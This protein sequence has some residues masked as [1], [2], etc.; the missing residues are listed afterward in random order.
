MAQVG[1]RTDKIDHWRT[2]DQRQRCVATSLLDLEPRLRRIEGYRHLLLLRAALQQETAT[3]R[4]GQE[5]V[6]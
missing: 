1:Q 4:G 2:S 3:M 6:A 5:Q